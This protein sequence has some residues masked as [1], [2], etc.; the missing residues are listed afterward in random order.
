M[1]TSEHHSRLCFALAVVALAF[2]ASPAPA[3]VMGGQWAADYSIAK[4]SSF[5]VLSVEDRGVL[6]LQL[7]DEPDPVSEAVGDEQDEAVKVEAAIL[8]LLLVVVEIHVTGQL[9]ARRRRCDALSACLSDG[10]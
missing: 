4:P 8:E 1:R 9:H 2:A 3:Q 7:P 6:E 5:K 10:G